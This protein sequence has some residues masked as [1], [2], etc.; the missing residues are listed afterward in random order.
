VLPTLPGAAEVKWRVP[1]LKPSE[2]LPVTPHCTCDTKGGV[3]LFSD[4]LRLPSHGLSGGAPSLFLRTVVPSPS[5][6]HSAWCDPPRLWSRISTQVIQLRPALPRPTRD[7][8]SV[9]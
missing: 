3:H 6:V 4:F 8:C 1:G 2:P 5:L 7:M 9:T